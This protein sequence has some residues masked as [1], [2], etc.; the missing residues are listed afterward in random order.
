MPDSK[1]N[2]PEEGRSPLGQKHS[3]SLPVRVYKRLLWGLQ[4]LF[5]A[6]IRFYQLAISPHLGA[7]CRYRPTC[8]EYARQA[9]IKYGPVRGSWLAFK[10]IMRCHP[11]HPGGYDPVP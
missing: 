4:K 7:N 1:H 8:S 11:F 9:I 2:L 3:S 5:L 10:R 6:L